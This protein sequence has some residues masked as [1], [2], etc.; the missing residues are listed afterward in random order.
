MAFFAKKRTDVQ[1]MLQHIREWKQD[2]SASVQQMSED[3]QALVRD[4]IETL[5]SDKELAILQQCCNQRH[6]PSW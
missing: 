5:D 3:F 1:K 4:K 2:E 6:E